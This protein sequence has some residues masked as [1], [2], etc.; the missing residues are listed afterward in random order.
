MPGVRDKINSDLKEAIKNREETACLTLRGLL[1]VILNKD[2]KKEYEKSEK[3]TDQE[4]IETVSSEVKKRRDSISDFSKGGRQDLVDK[5]KKEMEVLLK[6]LPSQLS[7]SEL[8]SIVKSAIDEVGASDMS[9]LGKVMGSLMPK[10][11]GRADGA[12]TTQL[13]KEMLQ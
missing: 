12:K 3:L 2:K 1:A 7:D 4:I 8:R 11:R 13:V 5:E 10:V 9:D 6:Y